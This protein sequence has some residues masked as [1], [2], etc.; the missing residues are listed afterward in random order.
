M[1]DYQFAA[2]ML[3]LTS[4]LGLVLGLHQSVSRLLIGLIQASC[5][6]WFI[7][8]LASVIMRVL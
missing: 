5:V 4:T 6:L 1:E 7:A 2:I 8:L 3:F